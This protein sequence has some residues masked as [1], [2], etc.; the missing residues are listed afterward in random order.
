MILLTVAS[1]TISFKTYFGNGGRLEKDGIFGVH[2]IGVNV[3]GN[4]RV[5][6][7]VVREGKGFVKTFYNI[8]EKKGIENSLRCTQC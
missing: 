2:Q 4:S 7:S 6:S 8:V 3:G 5:H 1:S